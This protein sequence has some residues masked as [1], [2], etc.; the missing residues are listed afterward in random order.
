[1]KATADAISAW[2]ASAPPAA[3]RAV[4]TCGAWLSSSSSGDGASGGASGGSSDWST[5]STTWEPS[6]A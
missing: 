2:I 5:S 3:M 4:A 1:M 6:A